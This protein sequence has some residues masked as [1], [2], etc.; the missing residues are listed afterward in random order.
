MK[1][2]LDRVEE[3]HDAVNSFKIEEPLAGV[4][5]PTLLIC[6]TEDWA[7]YPEQDKLASYLP[8]SQRVEIPGGGVP[9]VDHMPQEFA[10]AV[11]AFLDADD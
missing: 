6:G 11:L 5:A 7:A 9:L 1:C 2:G 3:G 10:D 4:R 8:G